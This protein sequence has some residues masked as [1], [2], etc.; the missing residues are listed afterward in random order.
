[1]AR[2][3]RL[4]WGARGAQSRPTARTP[5]H[6]RPG[7]ART[8]DPRIRFPRAERQLNRWPPGARGR[9]STA[10]LSPQPC[11][12]GVGRRHAHAGH[13]RPR[14]FTRPGALGALHVVLLR[15]NPSSS[16]V[17]LGSLPSLMAYA[18]RH[19][20]RLMR[21]T[22]TG[23]GNAPDGVLVESVLLGGHAPPLT[24]HLSSLQR[25]YSG[26]LG[27]YHPESHA[28]PRK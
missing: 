16:L 27:P 8:H 10:T 9:C 24:S 20:A 15:V 23:R 2:L 21:H 4:R 5:M 11:P 14:T 17:L 12:A 13:A 25:D 26:L 1:M 19:R 28:H 22:T 6:A 3:G 18:V 7:P